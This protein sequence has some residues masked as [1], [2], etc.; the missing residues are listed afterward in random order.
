M[1]GTIVITGGNGFVGKHLVKE[2]ANEWPEAKLVVWD[3]TING[4][5]EGVQGTEVDITKPESYRLKLAEGQPKWI[6]HLAAI[7]PIPVA[8][9]DPGLTR[10]VNVDATRDLLQLVREAAG[11]TRVLAISSSDI[12]G[13]TTFAPSSLIQSA[14]ARNRSGVLSAEELGEKSTPLPELGLD[15]AKPTNPYAASK[16]AMEEIIERDFNDLV[17]RARPFPHI[18]PG[19]GRGFVTADFASQIAAAERGLQRPVI[20]VGNLDTRRDFTD[21]RDVVRAYRLLMEKGQMGEVYHVASEKA[22]QIREVLDKLVSMVNIKLE[23]VQ[24]QEKVRKSDAKVLAGSAKK[25]RDRT[26][27]E[28]KISL[29]RSL[30]DILSY[31]REVLKD[32]NI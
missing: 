24:D 31:W 26:G 32:E 25:L 9:K 12:Y 3:R 29:D 13:S 1:K 4:L 16:L 20:R 14:M 19:Q 22:V 30:G 5:P 11:D 8:M 18:G 10:R 7:A 23:I 27:W 21:V 28:A 17:I 6:V 15:E 2:L